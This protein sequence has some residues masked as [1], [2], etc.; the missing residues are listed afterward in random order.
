M[1]KNVSS[2]QMNRA[3]RLA[4]KGNLG[5]N[6][7]A[8]YLACIIVR[9]KLWSLV[10]A[11]VLRI[12]AVTALFMC[13]FATTSFSPVSRGKAVDVSSFN[14]DIVIESELESEEY[15]ET[16]VSDEEDKASLN[17]LIV[18]QGDVNDGT[19]V[20]LEAAQVDSTDEPTFDKSDWKLLL[21]NKEHTIPD[22]YTFTLGTIKGSMKCDERIL[23]PLT[24]MFTA[25]AQ[26]GINLVVCSPYRDISRQEYLFDRKMKFYIGRGYSYIDAYKEASSVVTVPGASEHQIGISLDII[27]DTYS[28][29]NEGF[30]DTVAGRWLMDNAHRYGFILRYPKDKEEITGII[31]EPWHYRYVGVEAATIIHEK[32]ICLEEFIENL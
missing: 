16:E 11:P 5:L 1:N 31:Y 2:N 12:S 20:D 17:D 27:C 32:N 13:F 10:K 7:A 23:G 22:D 6:I 25:A 24:E 8:V 14:Q 29:L 30:G 3:K 21:I 18:S 15:I 26:D 19:N 9:N 28:Q 4:S